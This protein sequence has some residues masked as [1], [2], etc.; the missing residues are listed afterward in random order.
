MTCY[1]PVTCWKSKHVNATGKRSLVFQEAKGDGAP[2]EIPCGGCVGCRLDRAA[3]W[4]TRLLHESKQHR[5]NCFLTLTYNDENL[6]PYGSLDKTHFQKFMMRLRSR[7]YPVKVRYYMCGE[8]GEG[9]GRPHY[10]AILFGYDFADKNR[11]KKTAQ[12]H[13]IYHSDILDDLWS[14][15]HCWVGSVTADSCGTLLDT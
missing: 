6:P 8:Y 10:H 11:P 5:M 3:E 1:H 15:G 7:I 14:Y 12:G 13:S 4:Q 2:L 9:T